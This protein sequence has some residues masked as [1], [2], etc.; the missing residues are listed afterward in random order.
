VSKLE[1]SIEDKVV[2][3]AKKHKFL[4]PKVKFVESG[5]P[6]RLFI[7]PYGHTIFIEF[8]RPG[9]VPSDIQYHRLSELT[10]RGIPATWSDSVHES[11]RILEA[12]L[13]TVLGSPP[14]SD[15]SDQASLVAGVGRALLGPRAGEDINCASGVQD[16]KGEVSC[17]EDANHRT[18][19]ARPESVAG[20]GKEVVQLLRPSAYNSTWGHKGSKS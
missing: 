17:K 1:V 12:A 10:K 2:K 7:S 14:V 3:W 19:E 16:L 4:T 6:D 5:Y 11:I 20:R 18:P 8:K 13:E 15:T 9:E